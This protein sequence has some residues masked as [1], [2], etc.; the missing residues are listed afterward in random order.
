MPDP[1][2][3]PTYTESPESAPTYSHAL[4]EWPQTVFFAR[5]ASD[6]SLVQVFQQSN[7]SKIAS[8][9]VSSLPPHDYVRFNDFIQ[10]YI[11]SSSGCS[12]Q[13]HRMVSETVNSN[14]MN[15]RFS[16]TVILPPMK[17][18]QKP[19]QAIKTY[20]HPLAPANNRFE[21]SVSEHST[22]IRTLVL[23]VT[24]AGHV[25]TEFEMN[26]VKFRWIPAAVE[27][28]KRSIFSKVV[29]SFGG[30][31]SS[32]SSSSKD[33]P[34]E[35]VVHH[36]EFCSTGGDK[37]AWTMAAKATVTRTKYFKNGPPPTPTGGKFRFSE[38]EQSSFG[39]IQFMKENMFWYNYDSETQF[40]A[41]LGTLWTVWL[42]DALNRDGRLN[43][44]LEYRKVKRR[45]VLRAANPDVKLIN[46]F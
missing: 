19:N 14:F 15:S 39:S 9:Q 40:E 33:A 35:Q 2:P 23:D 41:I 22:G 42:M 30:S 21:Y 12:V 20:Y 38:I 1:Q 28:D 16:T 6:A 27:V 31:S 3:P 46:G 17:P 5:S 43:S 44:V 7:S 8:V 36:L 32:S 45:D 26:G 34:A 13:N 24:S 37:K 4:I 10:P 18:V 25:S 11:G 29:G